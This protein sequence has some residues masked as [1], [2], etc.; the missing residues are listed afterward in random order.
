MAICTGLLGFDGSA[1][2]ADPVDELRVRLDEVSSGL[3]R[4]DLSGEPASLALEKPSVRFGCLLPGTFG[5]LQRGSAALETFA[6]AVPGE[7]PK[8]GILGTPEVLLVSSA[9][10]LKVLV[11]SS[12]DELPLFGG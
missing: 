1:Q 2:L 4:A 9:G 6:A 3:V 8:A 7:E 11:A 5:C 12:A 10:R